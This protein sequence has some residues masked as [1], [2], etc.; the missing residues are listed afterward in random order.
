M[1]LNKTVV[2][3]KCM[4]INIEEQYFNMTVV[5]DHLISDLEMIVKQLFMSRIIKLL[6]RCTTYIR[7]LDIRHSYFIITPSR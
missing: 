2:D 5:N 1:D 3:D 4:Y 6:Q 7:S